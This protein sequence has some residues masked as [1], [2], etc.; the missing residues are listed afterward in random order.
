MGLN[1]NEAEPEPFDPFSFPAPEGP[2]EVVRP[3]LWM[4]AKSLFV[5][6]MALVLIVVPFDV[7]LKAGFSGVATVLPTAVVSWIF[8]KREEGAM[9]SA[10][11]KKFCFGAAL[12]ALA[13]ALFLVTG[14]HLYD[15]LVSKD[16]LPINS[17]FQTSDLPFVP[18]FVAV[19]TAASYAM[20]YFTVRVVEFVVKAS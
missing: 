15:S 4:Y 19:S 5:C 9:T 1:I 16:L 13:V 11:R 20:N 2:F 18:I 7:E 3:Y 17:S 10:E 8:I 14:F 12:C 6:V